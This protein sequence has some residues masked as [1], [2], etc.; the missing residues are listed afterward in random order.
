MDPSQLTRSLRLIDLLHASA[1][2]TIDQLA[3]ELAVSPR[4]VIRDLQSLRQAGVQV[5]LE[6]IHCRLKPHYH[7]PAPSLTEEELTNLAVAAHLGSLVAGEPLRSL[8]RPSVDKLLAG[9]TEP[10]RTGARHTLQALS[11]DPSTKPQGEEE[12]KTRSAILRA[13][14][15]RRQILV[16]YDSEDGQQSLV[17]SKV[18]PHHLVVSPGE[19]HLVGHSTWH[20]DVVRFD[21]GRIRQTE[22]TDDPYETR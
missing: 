3:S 18:T 21:V 22:L 17:S 8:V 7:V 15:L 13:I 6:G 16:H 20:R 14:R 11:F 1:D 12:E 19:W 5:E 4:T 9:A 10:V 2:L